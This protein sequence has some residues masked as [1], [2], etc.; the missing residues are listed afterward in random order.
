MKA[1]CALIGAA[2]LASSGSAKAGFID[3]NTTFSLA[4]SV[5]RA[6]VGEHG[7]ALKIEADGD[8]IEIEAQDPHNPNHIDRWRYGIVNYLGMIPLRR[9]T[10]P[11]PVD[12]TLIN[13]DIAANLF[14]L[15][16]VEF[17]AAP[18]LIEAAIARASAGRGQSHAHRNPAADIHPA[19]TL[20]RRR[21]LDPAHR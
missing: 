4:I 17:S 2:L 12:P 7:R 21:A 15:D 14:D 11:E 10:G 1:L 3:D 20:K 16:G 13:P 5:L 9:L 19:A 8:G 6:A 18:K